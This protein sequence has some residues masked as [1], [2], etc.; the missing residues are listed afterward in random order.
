MTRLFLRFYIAVVAVLALAWFLQ[1]QLS[2]AQYPAALVQL[3]E[4]AHRGNARLAADFL[5]SHGTDA[6]TLASLQSK[7]DCPVRV[8]STSELPAAAQRR[9]NRDESV[10]FYADARLGAGVA[11][12]L[13]AIGQSVALGP[14]PEFTH[15]EASLRG[16]IVLAVEA[17]TAAPPGERDVVLQQLREQFEFDVRFVPVN[18]LAGREQFRLAQ[19]DDVVFFPRDESSFVV[20]SMP[21]SSEVVQFGPF[22]NMADLERRVLGTTLAIVLLVTAVAIALLLRP[23]ARQLRLVERTAE[24]IAGGDLAARVDESRVYS[25]RPLAI[26]FNRMADRTESLLKSQRELLQAVSHELRTPLSRIRFA[27]DLLESADDPEERSRRLRSVD[28]ATEELDQL[29]GELLS[30]VRMDTIAEHTPTE[31]L[32]VPE[33]LSELVDTQQTL[34]PA[35]EFCIAPDAAD[36]DEQLLV[37]AVGFRRA[38]GNI[39]RNAGR[40]ARH[41]VTVDAYREGGALVIDVDDDGPGIAESDRERVFDPFVRAEGLGK[42]HSG[43]VGLGLALVHRIVNQHG[44]HATALSNPSGGCRLRTTWPTADDV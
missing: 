11:A 24:S 2:S 34:C 8:V 32:N 31:V 42:S 29:I 37:D 28:A 40:F 30:Y 15:Y 16:G 6:D 14:F 23:V 17:L 1:Q 7:F 4:K 26:M 25:S 44:G 19:G 3:V 22:P 20:T 27:A 9:L 43:G 41:R 33:L 18:S 36:R 12:S 5:N 39:L 13:E 38:L 35:I 21:G 10:V